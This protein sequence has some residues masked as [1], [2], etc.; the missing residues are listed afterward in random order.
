VC[1]FVAKGTC[2]PSQCPAMDISAALLWSH[3]SSFETSC[4]NTKWK[5]DSEW[6]IQ[7]DVVWSW[8]ILRYYPSIYLEG[9]KKSTKN[10]AGAASTQ[11]EN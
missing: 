3:Y 9:L 10:L 8:P 5:E 1:V 4:H 6:W 7:R 2:L 11:V